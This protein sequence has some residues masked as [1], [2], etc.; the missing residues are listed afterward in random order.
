MTE[1][2]LPPLPVWMA[3]SFYA[4]LLLALTALANAAGIDLFGAFHGAGIAGCTGVADA[5]CS[6][7]VLDAGVRAVTA[8]QTLLPVAFGLWAWLERRAPGYRLVW[9]WAAKA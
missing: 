4:Q 1:T 9:P 7:A 5:A 8:V 6:D 3:R 2:T